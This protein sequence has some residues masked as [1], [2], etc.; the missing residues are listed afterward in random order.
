MNPDNLR[1]NIRGNEPLI[2]NDVIC[3]GELN[4]FDIDKKVLC[5]YQFV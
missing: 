2:D 3:H 1:D 4:A 5:H